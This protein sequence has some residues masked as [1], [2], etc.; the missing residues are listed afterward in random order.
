[1][2][3]KTEFIA[4]L[5]TFSTMAYVIFVNPQILSEA[6]MNEG[7]SMV[8]T[9]LA[10][11]L[12]CIAM[13]LLGN[14]PFALAPGMGLSAYF[15]YGI[16]IGEG[17]SWQIAL[18]CCFIAGIIFFVLNLLRIREHIMHAI[19]F[20]LRIGTTAGIGL[21]LTLIGMKNSHIIVSHPSTLVTLGPITS[22][23]VV[24]TLFGV[25]VIGI[26]MHYGWKAAILISILINYALGHLFGLITWKGFVSLP[27]SLSPTFLQLDI[28]GALQPA[29]I[30]IV[31]SFV[32]VAIF[33]TAGTLLGLASQAKLLSKEGKIPKAKSIL[34]ADAI[35][36]TA[37]SLLGTSPTTT[38]LES[39]AGI[40]AGGRTGMTALVVAGLFLLTLFFAPIATTI[41]H[42]AIAPALIVIGSLMF[43]QIKEVRWDD[44]TDYIPAFLILFSI[45]LSFSIATGIALGFIIYPLLKLFCGKYLELNWIIWVIAALFALRFVYA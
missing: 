4:G 10:S 35:G 21:F 34:Y 11:S 27:P 45:P 20:P 42:F 31:L 6:G 43:A 39:A 5:T 2:I 9:I 1:M 36:T 28:M 29:L 25:L 30:P 7:A 19:P 44:P 8:A 22:P 33:D 40:A 18:G 16:V 32:F 3:K 17:Y 24:L 38:Y 14:Y 13:A 23:E 15:T 12:A 41:P 26:L 37:G